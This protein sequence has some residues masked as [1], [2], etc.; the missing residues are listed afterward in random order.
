[1][2]TICLLLLLILSACSSKKYVENVPYKYDYKNIHEQKINQIGN[3]KQ[4][5]FENYDDN[6]EKLS[7]EI[8]QLKEK[9]AI[10]LATNPKE[11]TNYTLYGYIDKWLGTPYKKNSLEEKGADCIYFIQTL[12]SEVYGETLPKNPAGM[13]MNP[14]IES[15]T[16]R[17]YLQEGDLIFFRY[18][19]ES[20]IS[21]VGIY[22]HNDRIIACGLKDGLTIY[23]FNDDYFQSR[24]VCAGRLKVKADK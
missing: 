19:K 7:D 16:G 20:P 8:L 11:I 17:A 14:A 12:F 6:P 1:M 3:I 15:F 18:N 22:L 24:Y 2:K 5:S 4:N 9:Y 10:L 23:N 13:R 21:D